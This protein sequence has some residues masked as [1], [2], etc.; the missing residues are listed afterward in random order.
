M[1]R[2]CMAG[3]RKQIATV[4]PRHGPLVLRVLGRPIRCRRREPGQQRAGVS[5]VTLQRRT[6]APGGSI[7]GGIVYAWSCIEIL[8][9]PRGAGAERGRLC[10]AAAGRE[11]AGC[12]SGRNPAGPAVAATGPTALWGG[13]LARH[14]Q[15]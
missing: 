13:N 8:V 1:R 5:R 4:P 2:A 10:T 11:P 6:R 15:E 7:S 14:G 9:G 3:L 12:A